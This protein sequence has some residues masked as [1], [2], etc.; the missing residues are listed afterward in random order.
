MKTTATVAQWIVRVAG[1]LLVILGAAFW[2]GRGLRFVSLH[3]LL[4]II[5]VLALWVV[6]GT[7]FAAGSAALGAVGI[8]W[9]LVVVALGLVQTSLLPG[10]AHW[11]IQVIHLLVGLGAIALGERITAAV[12]SSRAAPAV[13]G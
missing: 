3:M 5:L 11:V 13:S 8:V 2:V 6:A 4:G 12:R 1:I 9:G 7:G 10:S